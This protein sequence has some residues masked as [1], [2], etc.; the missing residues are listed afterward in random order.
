MTWPQLLEGVPWTLA[1]GVAF[2]VS[3]GDLRLGREVTSRDETIR[4]LKEELKA[5]VSKGAEA[6][7]TEQEATRQELAELR[8]TNAE[9]VAAMTNRG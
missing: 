4:E 3:R 5:V 8:K 7:A 1:L 6:M 2:A 9:L